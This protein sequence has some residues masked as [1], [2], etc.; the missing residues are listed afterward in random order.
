MKKEFVKVFQER[1]VAALVEELGALVKAGAP[2]VLRLDLAVGADAEIRRLALPPRVVFAGHLVD[3]DLVDLGPV[4][5]E[6]GLQR[7]EGLEVVGRLVAADAVRVRRDAIVEVRRRDARGGR[8]TGGR[9]YAVGQGL[10]LVEEQAVLPGAEADKEEQ[11]G[12]DCKLDGGDA[13]FFRAG[14]G[15]GQVERSAR[16]CGRDATP[17]GA[18]V[19]HGQVGE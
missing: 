16:V 9:T 1:N 6:A 11:Q 18:A 13:V 15:A 3:E 7:P 10:T 19:C 12:A 14:A 5:P 2:V 17:D 8:D 4:A